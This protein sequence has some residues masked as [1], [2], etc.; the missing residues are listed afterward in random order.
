VVLHITRESELV[1]RLI[2]FTELSPE[3]V[4]EVLKWRNHPFVR[5]NMLNQEVISLESHVAFLDSLKGDSSRR[6]FYLLGDEGGFGVF[7]LVDITET[8]AVSGCYKNPL[9]TERRLG[10]R[11][12]DTLVDFAF[13]SLGLCTLFAEILKDNEASI[14]LH[15]KKGYIPY[16]KTENTLKMRLDRHA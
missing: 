3:Q 11:I 16:D 10:H 2:D 1:V 5:S 13:N 9:L 8:H 7:T 15:Q 4:Y 14:R 6:Y 12:M